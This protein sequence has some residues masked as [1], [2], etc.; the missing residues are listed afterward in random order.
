MLDDGRSVGRRVV[1]E[2]YLQKQE[3]YAEQAG[4][5]RPSTSRSGSRRAR[6]EP[7]DLHR[8]D[9]PSDAR[10][11]GADMKQK[12]PARVLL[13]ASGGVR[14]QECKASSSAESE[15]SPGDQDSP[16]KARSVRQSGS[17]PRQTCQRGKAMRPRCCAGSRRSVWL[18]DSTSRRSTLTRSTKASSSSVAG[19]MSAPPKWCASWRL[20]KRRSWPPTMSGADGKT[21]K[22]S[23]RKP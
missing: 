10:V 17:T 18:I 14:T 8:F 19:L 2:N 15:S 3:W 21:L 22:S 11:V 16:C 4:Y 5:E 6:R 12:C 1:R 23:V 13:R 20:A 7:H 9:T